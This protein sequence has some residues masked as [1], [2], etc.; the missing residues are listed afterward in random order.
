MLVDFRIHFEPG[1]SIERLALDVIGRYRGEPTLFRVISSHGNRWSLRRLA[2]AGTAALEQIPLEPVFAR[3]EAHGLLR[4]VPPAAEA[5]SYSASF[6]PLSGGIDGGLRPVVLNR[7][8]GRLVLESG[9]PASP[10][11]PRAASLTVIASG[12]VTRHDGGLTL[13]G[14][15]AAHYVIPLQDLQEEMLQVGRSP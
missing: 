8:G 15:R 11:L 1:G 2:G 12:P 9:W 7:D 13:I 6:H 14:D 5:A 10:R 4:L 3:L